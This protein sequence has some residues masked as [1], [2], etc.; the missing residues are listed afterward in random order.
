[1]LNSIKDY[2]INYKGYKTDRKFVVF[3][4]DDYGSILIP[5]DEVLQKLKVFSP[6]I[7]ENRFNKFDDIA[8]ADDLN[9]LF[10]VLTSVKDKNN[11]PAVFTPL[12]VVANPDF[13]KIKNDKFRNY[14][15]ETFFQTIGKKEDGKEIKALWEK[16]IKQKIFVPEF[17]G[18]EHFNVRFWMDYL[19][20]KDRN[21]LEAFLNNSI[22][23]R[24]ATKD[25]MGY[26]AAFDLISPDHLKELE[27]ILQDGLNLFEKSFGYRA[28]LFTP[29]ALLHNDELNGYLKRNGIFYV[30]MARSRREPNMNGGYKKRYHHMGQ[31]NKFG[32]S[33]I[34]RNVMFEPN[35]DNTDAVEKA[36]KDIAVAFK[37]KKPA[38]ISSH[39]VN[40]VGEKSEI[41]RGKGLMDLKELLQNIVTRWPDVEFIAVR[42]LIHII[43]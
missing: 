41:N 40:F 12:T 10:E 28:V 24:P 31:K 4:V 21:V 38:I 26:M 1:M 6:I 9:K 34:T 20:K 43:N 32:Q 5:S 16:G 17:H 18:R 3:L 25:G 15:Y 8:S 42:D 35:K 19:R 14:H 37:Y 13:E 39:R 11:N 36:M 2:I 30:D 23:I 29:P 22:G 33:Y 27:G 7:S